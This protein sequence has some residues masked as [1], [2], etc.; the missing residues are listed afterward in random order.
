MV[1]TQTTF[2]V[3]SRS[4]WC[5]FATF[6]EIAVYTYLYTP[7][8]GGQFYFISFRVESL[9]T[10]ISLDECIDLVVDYIIKGNPGIKLS[11]ALKRLH[12]SDGRTL[13]TAETHFLF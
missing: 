7:F 3:L 12:F 11:A 6:L 5:F 9:F 13:A 2:W 8:Y 4:L 10:N 1:S